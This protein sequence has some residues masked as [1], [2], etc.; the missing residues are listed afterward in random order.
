MKLSLKFLYKLIFI[1]IFNNFTYKIN[2]YNCY[3]SI[4]VSQLKEI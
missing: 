3:K 1:Q 4:I 2:P